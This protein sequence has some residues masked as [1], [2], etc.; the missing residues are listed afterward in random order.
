VRLAMSTVPPDGAYKCWWF[1]G[2][3][4]LVVRVPH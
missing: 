1:W 4:R 3:V 2:V